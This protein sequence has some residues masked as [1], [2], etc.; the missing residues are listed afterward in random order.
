MP[1]AWPRLHAQ[2]SDF[3]LRYN[4][5]AKANA[6]GFSCATTA[7]SPLAACSL[8]AYLLAIALSYIL[9]AEAHLKIKKRRK[10]VTSQLS[11][12]KNVKFIYALILISLMI[13]CVCPIFYFNK[14]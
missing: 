11:A 13:Y 8:K 12:L 9:I 1:R 5:R 4:A 7:S 14:I 3:Y 6:L 2:V 10:A